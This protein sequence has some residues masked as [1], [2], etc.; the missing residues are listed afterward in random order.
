MSLRLRD[1]EQS[2]RPVGAPQVL[3]QAVRGGD[4]APDAAS[5]EPSR[6]LMVHHGVHSG[7]F[8]VVGMT[9]AQVRAVVGPLVNLDPDSL[10][11]ING[12]PIQDENE[13]VITAEDQILH[14][15]K[16]SSVRGTTGS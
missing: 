6:N 16:M 9:V 12:H 1:R 14:F 15:V 7:V 4:T 5:P 8:P 2:V 3:G 13:R 10:A 11:T